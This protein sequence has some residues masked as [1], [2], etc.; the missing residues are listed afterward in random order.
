MKRQIRS[1]LAFTL[2]M[3]MA[4]TCFTCLGFA[5]GEKIEVTLTPDVSSALPGDVV[6]FTLNVKN[7]YYATTMRWPILFSKDVFEPVDER[8]GIETT[9][10]FDTLEG[11]F[12]YNLT[13]DKSIFTETAK[14]ADYDGFLVQW[15]GIA[16]GK[17][18]VLK[19][20]SGID[21]FTFQ[22]KV[23]DSAVASSTGSVIIPS[24]STLLYNQ[25]LTDLEE[26]LTVSKIV[27]LK[28]LQFVFNN[29]SVSVKSAEPPKLVA[30]KDSTTVIDD[31][32]KLIYGL[33]ERLTSLDAYVTATQDGTFRVTKKTGTKIGTGSTVELLDGDNVIDTYTIII[34]GDVNGDGAFTDADIFLIDCYYNYIEDL[35]SF[36]KR[37][38]DVDNSGSADPGDIILFDLV[39]NFKGELNQATGSYEA[40]K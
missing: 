39:Y 5:A 37:A 15:L 26:P 32:N 19:S 12:T 3:I 17:V 6:T 33:D 7:N 21:V 2:A 10:D 4:L 9:K 38:A 11:N 14:S 8:C 18:N 1:V 20:E 23:K 24:D 28:E 22:L 40:Y 13:P 30:V 16:S 36:Q 27:N 25:A 31:T 29:T 34:Y 35:D